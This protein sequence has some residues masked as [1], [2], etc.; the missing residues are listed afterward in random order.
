MSRIT[1]IKLKKETRNKPQIGSG[2][3]EFYR[4]M[5]EKDI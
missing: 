1:Y 4:K 2:L 5:R 3:N